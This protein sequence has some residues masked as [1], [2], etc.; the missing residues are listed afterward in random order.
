[1]L[2]LRHE[3]VAVAVFSIFGGF[4]T[5]LLLQDR[6]P[7]QRL[8]LAYVLVLDVGVLALASFRNWRWFT[9]LA[10]IGSLVLFGFWR[11]ELEPST[12][13]SQVGI[14]GIF[15][16]FAGATIAFHL[17]RK[18]ASRPPD[19]ALITL[20]AAAFYGISYFLIYDEYRPWMGGFTAALAAF[21]G[22]M[23]AACRMRG[24]A[25]LNLT[26]FSA[27]L[28]V[29]FAVLAVPIQL[30]GPW[31]SIAWGIEG[32]VLVWMSFPLKMR[33]LRWAGY[34]MF[35]VSAVW[36][37][38]IDTPGA[39]AEDFT[40]FLNEYTLSYAAAVALP[41]LAG[42]LLHR[43]REELEAWEHLA[44]PV[45]AL[46][47]VLFAALFVPVQLDGAW[48][49]VGWALEAVLLLWISFFLRMREIRWSGYLLFATFSLWM[50]VDGYSGRIAGG[51]GSLPEPLHAGQR[52]SGGVRGRLRV[53]AVAQARRPRILR[54][55]RVPGVRD[56]RRHRGGRGLPDPAGVAV[57][58]RGLGG[59]GAGPG[60]AV[61]RPA[62][63]RGP[64]VRVRPVR[65]LIRLAA[66]V[67]HPPGALEE[68]FTVFLNWHMLSFGVAVLASAGLA[69]L[70]WRQQGIPCMTGNGL[71][72]IAFA[73]AAGVFAAVAV[74]VQLSGVW[75]TIGW[76]VE[77][78]V[79]LVLSGRLGMTGMRWLG[80]CL[81]ACS[82]GA[83]ARA[84]THSM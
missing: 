43:R 5:P 67:G 49:T 24:D 10:W 39:F 45:F 75:I 23:A 81:L 61:L 59:R 31:I 8:L 25:Q 9:L 22:L 37:L 32:L 14:T 54:A 82:A 55:G 74:P 58:H 57:D 46:R 77:S 83:P 63:A 62:D 27:G 35:V 76:V 52:G 56:R 34:A 50:L 69:L 78:V 16:I 33:E 1:M 84:S 40:P 38:A 64:L 70:L 41:A 80:Y 48:V 47:S 71:S 20:N 42:W 65:R 19:L 18:Q 3:S 15:L 53:A 44:I 11:Q 26:L 60:V 51:P 72:H 29:V 79:L 2:A 7:D 30:G 36:L 73:L 28:A 13:L 17:V 68:D 6:L 21:Y 66:G 12:G 4:A